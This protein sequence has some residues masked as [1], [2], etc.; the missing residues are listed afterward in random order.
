MKP[1]NCR[2]LT[3]AEEHINLLEKCVTI[4]NKDLLTA[5]ETPLTETYMTL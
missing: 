2:N 1:M 4:K 3:I 5:S